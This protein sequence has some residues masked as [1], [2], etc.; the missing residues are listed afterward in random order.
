MYVWSIPTSLSFELLVLSLCA[1]VCARARML[2]V[3]AN[4]LRHVQ[5]CLD[6]GEVTSQNTYR[7][8]TQATSK[9]VTLC[10]PIGEGSNARSLHWG[11][12]SLEHPLSMHY[13]IRCSFD[14]YWK[15]GTFAR[16][17]QIK[18]KEQSS[19]LI[20]HQFFVTDCSGRCKPVPLYTVNMTTMKTLATMTSRLH[21]VWFYMTKSNKWC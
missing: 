6:F 16:Y 19:N 7:W 13:P 12:Q 21:C 3:C 11:R 15:R 5:E 17:R 4:C 1:C 9:C 20:T 18:I 14:L 2:C 10:G 8:M